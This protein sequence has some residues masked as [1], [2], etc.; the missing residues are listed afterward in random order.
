MKVDRKLMCALLIATAVTGLSWLYSHLVVVTSPSLLHRFYWKDIGNPM[1]GEYVLFQL[2]H[3]LLKGG[4]A[5]LTKRVAC[6]EGEELTREGRAFYCNGVYLGTA[7]TES[8]MG[9]ALPLFEFSGRIPQGKFFVSGETVDSFDSRY[10][11]FLDRGAS[12]QRLT[13]LRL[14]GI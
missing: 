14:P 2:T 4:Q 1:K 11:G 6:V 7:K 8:L 5:R 9:E 10:W 13:L 12:V 3:P